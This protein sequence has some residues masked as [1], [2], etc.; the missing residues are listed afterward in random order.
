[1]EINPISPSEKLSEDWQ[2]AQNYYSLTTEK[3]QSEFLITPILR[4]IRRT[5]FYQFIVFH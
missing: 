4:E 3:A 2:E 5:H 1:M